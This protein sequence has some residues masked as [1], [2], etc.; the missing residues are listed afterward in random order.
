MRIRVSDVLELLA[1]N[2][3]RKEVL[4]EHPDLEDEDLSA[5]LLFASREIDHAV[6]SA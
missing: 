3:S 5:C 6:L 4:Q 2:M 1:S